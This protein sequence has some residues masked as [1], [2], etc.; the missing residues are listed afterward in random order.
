MFH[1]LQKFCRAQ[2]V[3]QVRKNGF[4]LAESELEF[5][6]RAGLE[7]GALAHVA[8]VQEALARGVEEEVGVL[9]VVLGVRD[10]FFQIVDVRRLDVQ[11]IVHGG[12][13]FDVPDV[14]A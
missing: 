5:D 4:F 3:N 1:R 7:A 10:H 6:G 2:R 12:V 9:R 13:V 8:D 11:N 14:N